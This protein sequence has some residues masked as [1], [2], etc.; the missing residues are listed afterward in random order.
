[1][2]TITTA[3]PI[4]AYAKAIGFVITTVIAALAG[5]L[6]DNSITQPELINVVVL[7]LGAI[8]VYIVP[9]LDAGIGRY[10]KLFIAGLTAAL[11]LLS[12]AL[13]D[14]VTIAEWLQI[15]LAFLGAFGVY[16]V[17]NTRGR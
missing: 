14:G 11:V 13:T 17:P 3:P 2:T 15:T 7:G 8:L 1:M 12:S 6:T 5:A 9:N 16:A 4:T 10:L